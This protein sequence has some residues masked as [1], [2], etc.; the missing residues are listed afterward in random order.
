MAK[1][2]NNDPLWILFSN[3]LSDVPGDLNLEKDNTLV[4]FGISNIVKQ[5]KDDIQFDIGA[6]QPIF[7]DDKNDLIVF[8]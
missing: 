8:I 2:P 6:S 3:D 5:A 7:V 1:G 4:L